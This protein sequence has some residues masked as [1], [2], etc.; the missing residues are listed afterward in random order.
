MIPPRFHP[1][2]IRDV[3]RETPDAVSIAF[4]IPAEL[5]ADYA[6]EPGQ[7]LT[8]RTSLDGEEVRRSYSICSGVADPHLRVGIKKVAAG[9]FSTYAND[10]LK[11]GDTLEAMAPMGHFFVP[12]D[13]AARRHVVAFAAGSGITPI[14]GILRTMLA[15]GHETSSTS[16]TSALYHIHR[17]KR[18][19]ARVL[20]ELATAD[21]P[22]DIAAL[23]YLGAVIQETLRVH[24]TVPIVLRELTGPLTVAGV[25]CPAGQV[26]GIALPALHFNPDLWADPESFRPE[27]FLE[28]KPSPYQYA[29]FGGGYRRCIGAAFAHSELAVGIGTIMKTLELRARDGDRAGRPPR[30]VARGIATKPGREIALYVSARR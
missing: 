11:V 18:I 12:V 9:L 28:D 22:A 6:Y 3:R 27:R 23:P 19:R 13:A 4:D 10:S 16:M 7:Y 8:L 30:A 26:V 25:P 15:A 29:P 24:P 20:D 5:A 1:L 2:T 17:D 14:L 21:T